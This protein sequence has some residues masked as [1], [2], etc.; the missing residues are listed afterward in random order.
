[1]AT[2]YLAACGAQHTVLVSMLTRIA[3]L[4]TALDQ[5]E[6]DQEAMRGAAQK[7]QSIL[8]VGWLF[9]WRPCKQQQHALMDTGGF[10][11]GGRQED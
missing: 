11:G 5:V 4:V 6:Q 10:I 3:T 7:F 1:M 8:E 9:D 2:H